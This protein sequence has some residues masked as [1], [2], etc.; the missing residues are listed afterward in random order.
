V[1]VVAIA[2]AVALPLLTAKPASAAAA[3][4]TGSTGGVTLEFSDNFSGT[5]LDT[6]KWHTCQ[7]WATTT[8]SI[9]TNNE[10]ELYTK[11]NVSVSNGALKLQG[12]RETAVG[13]NGKTYG[14]TSGMV[15]TGGRSG[16]T[17]PGFTFTYGYVEARVKVPKGQGLWPAFWMLPTDHSWP[18]EIDAMEIL[19]SQPNV[20]NMTY[21]YLDGAGTHMRPG[22]SWAGPDFSAG[23]HTFGVDWQPSA[24]T[25]YIDGIQR[26]T[27]TDAAAI[28][29]KASYVLLNLAVGGSWPGAPDASTVFPANFLVDYLRVW[30]RFGTP[31]T[32]PP[33]TSSYG[34][35]VVADSPASY[36]RLGESSGPMAADAV[37]NNTGTYRNSPT[38]GAPSLLRSDPQSTAVSFDGVNDS[39]TV[40]SA[41]NLSPTAAVTVEAWVRPAA[42][43]ATGSFASVVTKA[44]SY[45]LQFNGPRLEFTT[46]QSG[47]RRRVQAAA[48][49][50]VAG[51]TYH[52]VGTYDGAVQRLF[53]NGAQVAS[54]LFTG[55]LSTTANSLVM[56]SWDANS[57]YL[58]GV[59]DEVAVYPTALTASR[60]ANHYAI[61]NAT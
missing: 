47:T 19:G 44:E 13:W 35:A 20:S 60:I 40:P 54:G 7:W 51:Q 42:I 34:S 52:V 10:L 27:F 29:N 11:N 57:E 39:V 38:L 3:Q 16:E 49:V 6:T 59:I 58:S 32:P 21:H 5:T 17:A 43:P 48:G 1:A 2:G 50:V 8:C 26:W 24:I 22:A 12:R 9:E 36:W 56:G 30:D 33:P 45:A 37:S 41:P 61:G 18:P 23:W 15:S 25:W 55:A 31:A 46:M 14:Y 53:V 28:T 4:P